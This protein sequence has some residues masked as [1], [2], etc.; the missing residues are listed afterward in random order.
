MYA[1]RGM[2]AAEANR[3][4]K[5]AEAAALL[6]MPYVPPRQ[7]KATPARNPSGV[8]P[9]AELARTLVATRGVPPSTSPT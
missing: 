7:A 2:L 6:G 8:T 1:M 9:L 5:K 3:Q 4:P